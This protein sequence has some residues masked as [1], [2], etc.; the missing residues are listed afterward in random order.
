MNKKINLKVQSVILLLFVYCD[1]TLAHFAVPIP[2]PADRLIDNMNSYIKENPKDAHGYYILGRIHYLAFINKTA[3]VAVF[4]EGKDSPPKVAEDWQSPR[5]QNSALQ[6]HARKLALEEFGFSSYP[7]LSQEERKKFQDLFAQKVEQLR[8]Q[9]WQPEKLNQSELIQHVTGAIDNFKKAIEFD[10]K[11]GLYHLG[12]ASL[13]EQYIN[14]VKEIDLQVFPEEFR[15]IIIDYAADVYYS[16]YELSIKESLKNKNIP[17]AGL[18]SLTGYEAGNA[19]IRLI[20]TNKNASIE[21][22]KKLSQVQENINKLNKLPRGAITPIIFSLEKIISSSDLLERNLQV[23][24]DLDGNGNTEMWPWVKPSTGILV[25]NEDG[26]DEITSGRQLFGSVT[27]W[28]FFNDG[29]HALDCL[30]DNRDGTLSDTELKGISIWFDT[31]SNGKSESGEIKSLEELGIIS[32]STKST[33]TENGWPAN[34]TG[35]KLKTGQT[36]QTYDWIA[37]PLK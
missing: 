9:N 1:I 11:N 2:F 23:K 5:F 10:P 26:K 31:N 7:D 28:L 18:R 15:S 35:I 12:L 20:K 34:K 4:N 13:L 36:I 21:Q 25:W 37:T 16:A 24:F 29:Y 32:I 17:L 30:D 8:K 33:S 27:W 14:Y 22:K 3:Q 6:E 19:F